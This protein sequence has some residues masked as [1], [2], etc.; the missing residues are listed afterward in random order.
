MNLTLANPS[1]HVLVAASVASGL[2]KVTLNMPLEPELAPCGWR[3]P[4]Q[5]PT[6]MRGPFGILYTL[7]VDET[8]LEPSA[9]NKAV[10]GCRCRVAPPARSQLYVPM[11]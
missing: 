1:A 9:P 11:G 8:G 6:L 5:R 4:H 7:L 3:C 10:A 2:W